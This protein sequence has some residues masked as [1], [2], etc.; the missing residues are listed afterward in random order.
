MGCTGIALLLAQSAA[1]H[2]GFTIPFPP[3]L[4]S[5][6]LHPT[7]L[8]VGPAGS[9]MYLLDTQSAQVAAWNLNTGETMV[10]GGIGASR[11]AFLEPV[12]LCVHD[13]SVYVLDRAGESIIVFDHRL[14]YRSSLQIDL[15]YPEDLVV[16]SW[17][18]SLV[19][20]GFDQRILRLKS[21]QPN[22]VFIDLSVVG[23]VPNCIDD[24]IIH[25]VN[26]QLVLWHSCDHSY[27]LFDRLGRKIGT[28]PIVENNNISS[29]Q[30]LI[31]LLISG[32][33]A[34]S[35]GPGTLSSAKLD[36]IQSISHSNIIID[37]VWSPPHGL[38]LLTDKGVR[39]IPLGTK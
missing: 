1:D 15:S 7:K 4:Q 24:M 19:L 22:E 16:N 27:T 33:W 9:W 14:N 34:P 17:G 32:L 5:L 11:E 25:P 29:T 35:S 10:T 28:R 21:G 3:K 13:L 20:S 31:N 38:Y 37:S 18:E 6:D 36:E 12:D 2:D 26:D 23:S 39:L 30:G 8:A